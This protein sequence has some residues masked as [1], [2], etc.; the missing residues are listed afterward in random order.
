MA[1]MAKSI[2]FATI[3]FKEEEMNDTEKLV[4]AVIGMVAFFVAMY[5]M[6]T[7]DDIGQFH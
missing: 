5:F 1:R 4:V 3:N 6:L 7:M 2:D